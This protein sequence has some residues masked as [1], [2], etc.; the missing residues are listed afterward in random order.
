[1][2]VQLNYNI[3]RKST[4]PQP[5]SCF[6]GKVAIFSKGCELFTSKIT[7]D[8]FYTVVEGATTRMTKG[9]VPIII[10]SNH[11]FNLYL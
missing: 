11:S 10:S 7:I 9:Q 2:A 1:M 5:K 3:R 6:T 8:F 4:T